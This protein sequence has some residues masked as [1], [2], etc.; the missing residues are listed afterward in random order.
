MAHLECKEGPSSQEQVSANTDE[1][2]KHQ[3]IFRVAPRFTGNGSK[4]GLDDHPAIATRALPT[5]HLTLD[6]ARKR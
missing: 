4:I 3:G 1:F 5:L 2:G 6:R